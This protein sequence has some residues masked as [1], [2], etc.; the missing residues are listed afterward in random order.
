MSNNLAGSN[1]YLQIQPSNQT[2]TGRISYKDG[3]PVLNF[4]IGEQDRYLIGSSVRLV[5]N[6]SIYKTDWPRFGNIEDPKKDET[7]A[8]GN[9][10][11][12]YECK[13]YQKTCKLI[14]NNF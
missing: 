5:G 13:T 14:D 12:I 4:I 10:I 1:S 8:K 9:Q 3:N 6:I 7:Y 2:S 11:K